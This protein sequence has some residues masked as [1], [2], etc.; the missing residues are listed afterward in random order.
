MFTSNPSTLSPHH[1][2]NSPS[3]DLLVQLAALLD[4]SLDV[5]LDAAPIAVG[6]IVDDTGLDLCTKPLTTT[7]DPI[8]EL[9][10]FVAPDA[11][12]IFGVAFVG[13]ARHVLTGQRD[14]RAV[15]VHLRT[16]AGLGLQRLHLAGNEPIN[17][18]MSGPAVIESPA[19]TTPTDQSSASSEPREPADVTDDVHL[20]GRVDDVVARAL[21]LPTVPPQH[22]TADLWSRLWLDR[23]LAAALLG[24]QPHDWFGAAALHPAV[25]LIGPA[26]IDDEH[27]AVD[28][29][30]ELVSALH[31]ATWSDLRQQAIDAQLPA[32]LA[33]EA[34]HPEWHDTGSFSR[35]VVL[36]F[37]PVEAALAELA[38]FLPTAPL[39]AIDAALRRWSC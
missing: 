6:A 21:G 28:H 3:T 23:L 19:S 15:A 31:S 18:P 38:E 13:R 17:T 32:D 27:W 20:V 8:G 7:N 5:R 11:F 9:V 1:P 30:D 22:T 36:P 4:T 26:G 24:Y 2:A 10:G 25:E 14:E 29:L 33:I 39:A 37:L 35:E 34:V 16:R 12:D